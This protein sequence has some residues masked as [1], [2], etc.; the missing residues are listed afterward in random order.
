MSTNKDKDY[1]QLDQGNPDGCGFSWSLK[2]GPQRGGDYTGGYI[3]AD[4]TTGVLRCDPGA[5][6]DDHL[7]IATD[8]DPIPGHLDDKISAGDG[9]SAVV[10]GNIHTFEQ[11]QISS[12]IDDVTIKINAGGE[13]YA[14]STGI[15]GGTGLKGGTGIQGVTGLI[16]GTGIQGVTGLVGGTG[17]QGVTGI[18]ASAYNGEIYGITGIWTVVGGLIVSSI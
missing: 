5:S 9:I 10:V 1:Y 15:Q 11:Y 17:I 13:M 2:G 3:V 6:F 8:N 18:G 7:V 4:P 14:T 12:K 16:G